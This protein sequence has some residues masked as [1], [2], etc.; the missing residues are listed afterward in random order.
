ML[1]TVVVAEDPWK[2]ELSVGIDG[3][4][5]VL[6]YAGEDTPPHGVDS[7]SPTPTSPA[8]VIYNYISADTEFPPPHAEVPFPAVEAAVIE[9]LTTEGDRPTAVDWQTTG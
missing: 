9:Y 5:G 8:P 1:L 6:H 7:K 2:S 4:K 3:D